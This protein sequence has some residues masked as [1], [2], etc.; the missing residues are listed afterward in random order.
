[1]QSHPLYPNALEWKELTEELER[2]KWPDQLGY[3]G[4]PRA[5]KFGYVRLALSTG[6][7]ARTITPSGVWDK[8]KSPWM[9]VYRTQGRSNIFNLQTRFCRKQFL[10]LAPKVGHWEWKIEQQTTG[11]FYLYVRF[12]PPFDLR[13]LNALS[14]VWIPSGQWLNSMIEANE[15]RLEKERQEYLATAV[16]ETG[17]VYG[18]AFLDATPEQ[19]EAMI[20]EWE[21]EE[22]D[23]PF[24]PDLMV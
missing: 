14:L 11:W 1:M 13:E 22:D 24:D 6:V 23:E 8:Y 16:G 15:Q 21:A 7:H 12:I 4:R 10:E 3:R 18:D 9:P 5:V 20:A 17:K 2:L 19:R